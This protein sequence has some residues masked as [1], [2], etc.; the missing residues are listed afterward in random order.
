MM[1][2][3]TSMHE[4]LHRYL[5]IRHRWYDLTHWGPIAVLIAW[6]LAAS[7]S[8]SSPDAGT[9]DGTLVVHV[10]TAALLSAS[11]S[12]RRLP[13]PSFLSLSPLCPGAP[14][15]TL[16]WPSMIHA[17]GTQPSTVLQFRRSSPRCSHFISFCDFDSLSLWF[18]PMLASIPKPFHF[19]G[20]WWKF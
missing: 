20:L 18:F 16:H 12:T 6:E 2:H 9:G 14:L 5:Q 11:L 4:F 8:L 13:V 10:P 19:F 7:P 1:A 15:G 3:S 17:P